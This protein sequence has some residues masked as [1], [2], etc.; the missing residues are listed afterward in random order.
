MYRSIKS[1]IDW[2]KDGYIDQKMD[3][4]IKRWIDWLKDGLKGW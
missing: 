2:L 1:W 4:S 3:R